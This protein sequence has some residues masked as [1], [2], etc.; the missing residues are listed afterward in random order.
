MRS[1]WNGAFTT[2]L[3]E[4]YDRRSEERLIAQAANAGPVQSLTKREL[5]RQS[6]TI[7][8]RPHRRV[9]AGM[10]FGPEALRVDALLM[11]STPT[12]AGIEFKAQDQVYRC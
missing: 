11:R 6:L 1:T 8:P 2:R 5:A 3:A 4:H 10:R 9:K 7:Y 12:A